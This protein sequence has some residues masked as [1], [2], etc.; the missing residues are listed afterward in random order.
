MRGV[1]LAL[2]S[3]FSFNLMHA[4]TKKVTGSVTDEKGE[5]LIGVSVS[6]K[7]TGKLTI[8]DFDGNFEIAT[9]KGDILIADYLGYSKKEVKVVDQGKISI[10]LLPSAENLDEV[11]VVG[12]GTQTKKEVTGAVAK[13]KAEVIEQTATPDLGTAIQG[14]IAGV[15]VVATSGEPGEESNIQIRGVN[16]ILGDNR[17]LYVVDGIPYEDDPKL[18]MNEI[19]SIDVL[20]DGASAAIYGTRG[21]AGVILITTKKAK[22]GQMNVRVNSYYGIQ[23]ITSS[24]PTL[25]REQKLMQLHLRGEALNGT[26]YGNTWTVIERSPHFITNDTNLF[27]LIENDNAVI[28]NHNLNI[29]GGKNGL[30]YNVNASYFSQEGVLYNSKYDRFNLRSNTNYKKGKWNIRTGISFRVEDNNAAPWGL[31][32]DAIRYNPLQPLL[33]TDTDV[34]DNVG[35][36]NEAQNISF[37]GQKLSQTNTRES[38]YFDVNI[39]ASYDITKE[40]KFTTRAAVSYNNGTQIAVNPIFVAVRDDGTRIQNQ[41]SSVTNASTLQKKQTWDGFLNYKKSFGSHNINLTLAYSAERYTYSQFL[42]R[43]FDLFNNDITVLNNA[44]QDEAYVESGT[45]RWTQD[46]ETTLIG[47]LFRAQYNY[48]GKYLFN[49]FVRRDGSSKFSKDPY[50]IFPSVSVGWNV[51]DEEFWAPLKRVVSQFKLRASRGTTGNN[52]AP[53]YGFAPVIQLSRDY[54]FGGA[55]GE[56][57]Y[58]GAT[59]EVFVEP[60]VKWETSVSK[61]IGLD[62]AMFQ[63]KLTLNVDLYQT[64]KEDMLLPVLVPTSSG[65]GSAD[66]S[67]VR[68]VGNMV[69][70]GVEVALGYRHRG[71]FSW[72]VAGTFTKNVNEVTKMHESN[73]VIWF[74]DSTISGHSNDQDL[75]TLVR[76]GYEA[77][78]FF[79]HKTDGVVS[80]QEQLDA[81]RLIDP[82]AG[83]GDLIYVDE[84]GDGVI[85]INDRTYAGSGIPDFEAGLNFGANYKGFDFS[86]QWYGAFG[87]DIL[88]G[89]KA[90]AY[91]SANHQELLYQWTTF[92]NESLVPVDRGATHNNYRGHTDYWLEDGTFLRLRNITLGY[93]IPKKTTQKIGINKLRVYVAAQNALTFTK[94]TGYDPEVGGNGLSTRGIDK[95]RYPVSAQ[96]RGG[97]QLEF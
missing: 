82:N 11:V 37:L 69:N 95:G 50:G 49:A 32:Q 16:S 36:E 53:D 19:E 72:N 5:P 79:L 81:Y 75:T 23:K 92:N 90:L 87:G 76:E 54:V 7:S 58:R 8:T 63:N 15:N 62:M 48:R 67:V 83:F 35:D 78:A 20:K 45:N 26:R 86:M 97:V 18:S 43:K 71:K 4:Q 46:R 47:S 52:G 77:G 68:N 96:I 39:N 22:E 64:D 60:D 14:Q 70:K 66:A 1:V 88:N 24:T 56:V 13:V 6:V 80:T 57:L 84:N 85:D 93:R 42:A 94:Y 31:I 17:P 10:T 25:N 74:D 21:A 9:K 59:Q 29:S 38:H 41:P 44:L 51:H 65:A 3:V 73:P 61:N 28:Q 33:V 89:N 27:D 40:L 34:L 2:I 30:S 91:K 55:S 12:Y